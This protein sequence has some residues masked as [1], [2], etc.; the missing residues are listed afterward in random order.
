MT[1][2]KAGHSPPR[3]IFDTPSAGLRDGVPLR[4]K[5]KTQPFLQTDKRPPDPSL[6]S[7]QE[8]GR[9]KNAEGR[10]TRKSKSL[11]FTKPK[12]DSPQS[13]A[14]RKRR[15]STAPAKKRRKSRRRGT[16]LRMTSRRR[17]A[18]TRDG[19]CD[20][21][22]DDDDGSRLT[23]SQGRRRRARPQARKELQTISNARIAWFSSR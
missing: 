23:R 6:R 5:A 9:Y 8:G 7:G 15:A 19:A 12:R 14:G 20:G 3:R 18:A 2:K 16:P 22:G 11:P 1:P 10:G 4:E 13:H 21:R 17:K